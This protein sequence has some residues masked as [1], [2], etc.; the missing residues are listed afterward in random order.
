MRFCQKL[1]PHMQV[2]L[3]SINSVWI[4]IEWQFLCHCKEVVFLLHMVYYIPKV[5]IPTENRF[6]ADG[7]TYKFSAW[8]STVLL[9]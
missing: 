3:L 4:E 9:W 7:C 5:K 8:Q 1:V 6:C 2:V